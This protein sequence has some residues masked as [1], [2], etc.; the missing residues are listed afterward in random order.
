MPTS[1]KEEIQDN[2]VARLQTITAANGYDTDVKNVYSDKIPMG[3]NLDA[4]DM[5]AIFVVGGDDTIER[6]HRQFMTRWSI[7]LQLLHGDVDDGTMHRFVRDIAKCI[8]ANSPTA[9]RTEAWRGS[10]ASGGIHESLFDVFL[11]TIDSDLN[12]IDANRFF[13]VH[14]VLRYKS[15]PYDL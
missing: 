1:K 9:Q 10:S 13:I 7:E 12:M 6:T 2:L 11:D 15:S 3:L 4:H 14:Y 8:F 5:P